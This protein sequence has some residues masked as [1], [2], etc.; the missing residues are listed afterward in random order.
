[1][2]IPSY[3]DLYSTLKMQSLSIY[4][5]PNYIGAISATIQAKTRLFQV[6]NVITFSEASVRV[7]IL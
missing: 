2:A 6:L 3:I 7:S 4:L 1:M 5:L